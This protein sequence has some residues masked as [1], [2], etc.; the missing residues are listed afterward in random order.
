MH[1]QLNERD[2]ET[3][4]RNIVK[5]RLD[6]IAIIWKEVRGTH[7]DIM[8]EAETEHDLY[9]KN[10]EFSQMTTDFEAL[11]DMLQTLLTDLEASA[12]PGHACQPAPVIGEELDVDLRAAKLPRLELPIFSRHY[13]DWENFCDL[14]H[15]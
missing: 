7:A 15:R 8:T 14:F 13:D 6:T 1:T 9:V 12:S 5:S 10:D 2:R 11:H 4:K 3:P